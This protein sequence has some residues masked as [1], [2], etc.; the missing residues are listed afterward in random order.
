MFVI[1]SDKEQT[2]KE[3]VKAINEKI[4]EKK[5]SDEPSKGGDPAPKAEVQKSPDAPKSEPNK[6]EKADK[7]D[8]PTGSAISPR[9]QL[10]LAKGSIPFLQDEESKVLEFWQIWSESIPLGDELQPGGAIEFTVSTS[11]NMEKLTWRTGSS[12]FPLS[13]YFLIPPSFAS[14]FWDFLRPYFSIFFF[15]S[16]S[17]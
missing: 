15:H 1:Y 2:T 5:K 14:L 3:W 8:Q 13:F 11:A 7:T 17:I 12:F 16:L 9:V 10:S 4:K 6:T